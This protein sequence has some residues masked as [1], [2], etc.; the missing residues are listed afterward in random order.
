MLPIADTGLQAAVMNIADRPRVVFVRGHGS[1][2]VDEDGNEYLD[3]VQGWAVNSLGHCHPALVKAI[4]EQAATLINASPAYFSN[5]MVELAT[6]IVG[7]SCMDKVFFTN[8]G[9]EAN[10][11]AIKLA[12]K[13]GS[14]HRGGAYEIIT[15]NNS[16]HGRSLATMSASGKPRWEK[17]F[18]PKVP[19]FIKVEAGNL[20]AIEEALSE[21]TVAVMLEPIQGEGGVV[22]MSANYLKALRALTD[23]SGT[24]LILDEVQTGMGRTGKFFAYQ[25]SGVE[26]DIMT[27]GKGLGGGVP[28]AALTAK[29]AVL[30]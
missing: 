12:R 16:F 19:G 1:Y 6:K 22:P 14:F 13:W 29:A 20:L 7:S 5:R 11:G 8:S 2:L 24:L 3:F 30:L 21:R 10:E 15:L 4:S 17:L 23:K 18:E 28:L 26:P 25:Q 9:A 27:L